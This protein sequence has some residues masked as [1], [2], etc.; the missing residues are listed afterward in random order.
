[1]QAILV[2]VTMFHNHP[3]LEPFSGDTSSYYMK[4]CVLIRCL[5]IISISHTIRKYLFSDFSAFCLPVKEKRETMKNKRTYC[6]AMNK[7]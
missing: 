7:S 2:L 3:T 5:H 6:G 1:M 4:N